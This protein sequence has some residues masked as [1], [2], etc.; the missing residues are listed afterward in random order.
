MHSMSLATRSFPL[1][2]GTGNANHLVQT[3]MPLA[4][5]RQEHIAFEAI[6]HEPAV[7]KHVSTD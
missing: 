3:S 4:L 6:V 1:A 5:I 7:C 2:E